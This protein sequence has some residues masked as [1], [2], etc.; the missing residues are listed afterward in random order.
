MIKLILKLAVVALL[1][2]A[3]WRVG[4]AY[5]AHYKFMDS[6]QQ[7]ALFRG[8]KTDDVLRQRIFELASDFD[9]PVTDGDVTL[10][11]LEHHTVVDGDYVRIIEIV[12]G[13][14]YPWEFT[15]HVDT[16]QGAL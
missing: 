8:N 6:V 16:L 5:V 1:A 7:A 10:T 11:T 15:F 4:S 9:I 13:Y 2:N 3:S 14:K 12:P